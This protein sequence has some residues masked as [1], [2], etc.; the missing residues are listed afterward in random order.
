MWDRLEKQGSIGG[1]K[2]FMMCSLGCWVLIG[3]SCRLV[4]ARSTCVRSNVCVG[5]E[6]VFSRGV[7]AHALAVRPQV[8]CVGSTFTCGTVV[9]H[10]RGS[11]VERGA[12]VD[13]GLKDRLTRGILYAVSLVRGGVV[14]R[15]AD[16]AVEPCE[17]VRLSGN[18]GDGLVV[19][20]DGEHV[21]LLSVGGL[22]LI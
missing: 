6:H 1:L 15:V 2:A 10:G 11:V 14:H 18:G 8:V 16:V 13:T 19:A 9:R 4:D 3:L 22:L 12:P 5:I 21:V 20:G 7:A 17:H